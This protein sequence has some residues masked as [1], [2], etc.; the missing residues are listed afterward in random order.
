MMLGSKIQLMMTPWRT[1]LLSQ[2]PISQPEK[3]MVVPVYRCALVTVD[4]DTSDE[5]NKIKTKDLYYSPP[6]KKNQSLLCARTVA[7]GKTK[8]LPSWKAWTIQAYGA[9]RQSPGTSVMH[10]EG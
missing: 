10:Q 8:S 9:D 4:S 5:N 7:V 6:T 3:N 1:Q 2:V